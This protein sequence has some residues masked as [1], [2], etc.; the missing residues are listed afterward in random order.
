M[1]VATSAQAA[2]SGVLLQT[3]PSD[4][5]T[6]FNGVSI[7]GP[8]AEELANARNAIGTIENDLQRAQAELALVEDELAL[9]QQQLT[10]ASQQLSVAEE[11]AWQAN[12]AAEAAR[13]DLARVQGELDDARG[14]EADNL[15]SLTGFARDAYMFGPGAT[16]PTLM[17]IGGMGGTN[18]SDIAKAQQAVD[19]VARDR[20]QTL[21]ETE[22]LVA[23]TSGLEEEAGLMEQARADKEAEAEA[24]RQEAARQHAVVM[25]LLDETEVKVGRQEELI[26]ELGITRQ[27]AI[28]TLDE[29]EAEAKRAKEAA[30]AKRKAEEEARKRAEEAARAAAAAEAAQR[31]AKEAAAARAAEAAD[32]AREAAD[33]AEQESN[34]ATEAKNKRQAI[35]TVSVSNSGGLSTVGGITVSSSIAGQLQRLL[36]DARASGIVLG[37]GGYRS[38][39]TTARLRLANGCPDVYTSP[40]SSCRVPTAI[41]GSSKHERGLA[42]DFTYQGQTICFPR[43]PANCRGNAG[44]DWLRANAGNYG[45]RGIS[46]EAWHFEVG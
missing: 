46:S 25:E 15:A 40:A 2:P 41:P 42:V 31:E 38:P 39:E 35:G 33:K 21:E 4:D 9:V 3:A 34:V 7:V 26:D 16:D 29:L 23:T 17:L 5:E 32:R 14:A 19:V 8:S 24:T 13:D 22:A 1:L 44:F 18:G 10:I 12:D 43:G 11:V 6:T 28:T 20:T 36:N 30:E 45:F 27:E 37:G